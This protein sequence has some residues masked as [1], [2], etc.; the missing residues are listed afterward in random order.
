MNSRL[1][2]MTEQGQCRQ[3]A[4][5]IRSELWLSVI[6]FD[7]PIRVLLEDVRALFRYKRRHPDCRFEVTLADLFQHSVNVPAE[8][9]SRSKR[10]AHHRQVTIVNL[11]VPEAKAYSSR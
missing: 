6:V 4:N 5:I 1:S 7:K 11:N 3:A 9:R 2:F 8:G 10:I